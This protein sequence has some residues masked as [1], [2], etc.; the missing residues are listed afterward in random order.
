MGDYPVTAAVRALRAAAEDFTPHL[1]RY[2]ERGG[3]AVSARE[4]GVDEHCVVKTL[5]M[6]DERNA[7]LV[8]LMHGDR[9]VSKRNLARYIGCKS[10]TP[11]TPETAHKHSG[12]RVGGTSP[13]GLRK[14]MPIYVEASILDLDRI[15]INGGG[16]GFLLGIA[17][18]VLISLLRATPVHAA[19][20]RT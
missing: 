17:P 1:Y 3:T 19:A 16:R 7:P 12:Y 18:H 14:A 8:V 4:L 2:E 20:E 6:Q 10:V 15:Y 11:C 13:F 9:E 5:V